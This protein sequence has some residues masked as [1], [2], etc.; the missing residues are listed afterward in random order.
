MGGY[1]VIEQLEFRARCGVTPD[2]RARPQLLAVDLELDCR[3]EAA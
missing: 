1:I 2:E 3:L